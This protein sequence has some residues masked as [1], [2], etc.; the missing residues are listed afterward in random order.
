[1]EWLEWP[2]YDLT[3]QDGLCFLVVRGVVGLG[4]DAFIFY[5]VQRGRKILFRGL[6]A[7]TVCAMSLRFVLVSV[8]VDCGATVA[9]K[10]VC[11]CR[12][13]SLCSLYESDSIPM[14]NGFGFGFALVQTY[15]KKVLTRYGI[16]VKY[17]KVPSLNVRNWIKETIRFQR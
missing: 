1:M 7:G 11:C 9:V 17:Y 8:F 4:E 2:T 5:S 14:R 3:M 15:E 12:R 6:Y 13:R 10:F 16:Y